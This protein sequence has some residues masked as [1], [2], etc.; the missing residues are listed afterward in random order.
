L[1]EEGTGRPQRVATWISRSRVDRFQRKK[2]CLTTGREF[3]VRKDGRIAGCAK[4]AAFFR[5]GHCADVRQT[6]RK[7]VRLIRIW[8]NTFG[9]SIQASP[10]KL[11]GAG[12]PLRLDRYGAAPQ[13]E[14]SPMLLTIAIIIL[15][16]WALGFL[17]FHV[18]SGLIHILLVIGI[19]VL[20][21]HFVR[22][23]PTV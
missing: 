8:I 23:R 1:E 21:I 9:G 13:E 14:E 22:G 16:L 2:R 5:A 10:L 12:T 19:I 4:L 20:I 7:P 15:I 11:P 18:T 6:S 3:R 17:A